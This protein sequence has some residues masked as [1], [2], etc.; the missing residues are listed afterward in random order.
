VS[1]LHPVDL[2]LAQLPSS[3]VGLKIAHLTDLHIVR[4]RRRHERIVDALHGQ[5]LDLIV[6]TGDYMTR[7]GHEPVAHEV[8][9]RLVP[10]L[11]ARLG[12]FGVFG[13]HDTPQFTE[14]VRDLPLTWLRDEAHA[15]AGLPLHIM[16]VHT[17][18]HHGPD[19]VALLDRLHRARSQDEPR[20]AS[21]ARR[22]ADDQAVRLLLCHYPTYLPT[23]ADMGVHVMFSGHT[24][25]G[26]CRTPWGA[27]LRN[28]CDLPLRLTS[29]ILRHR[30][31]LCVVSRGLGEV[32]LPLRT[33]CPPHLPIYTLRRGPLPGRATHHVENV[34][35]W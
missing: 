18:R 7:H 6:L 26:Q 8:L 32:T 3:L 30:D 29:G 14:L 33:F 21:R 24:H 4:H 34:R 1:L 9:W 12:V 13:N 11:K 5:R 35:P 28:S 17:D 16:G 20:S 19:S 31:T 10:R 25:G 2:P 15:V 22:D 27:P 23:A